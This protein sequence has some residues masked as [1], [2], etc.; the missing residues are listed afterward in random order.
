MEAYEISRNIELYTKRLTD[1]KNT[2]NLE[3]LEANIKKDEEISFSPT[4]YNDIDKSQQVLKRIKK[5][6]NILNTFK[7]I[8]TY[9][10]DLQCLYDLQKN[11]EISEADNNNDVTKVIANVNNLLT[12]FEKQM[13]LNGEYDDCDALMELHPGAGGTE[14]QDWAAMLLRMYRRYAEAHNFDFEIVD[15]ID[16][17]EAGLKSVT[18]VVKGDNAYGYLKSEHGVH[19]MVRISPFDAGNR[20]HT[21]FAG[22]I[23]TPVI[24]ENINIEIKQEDIRVDTYRSTGSGGQ[25]VNK[26]D[27]AVR[28]THL[29]TGI[30]V[31][32]QSQRS[33]LQNREKAM[34][35]LKSKLYQLE[36]EENDRK[37]KNINGDNSVNGFGGQIRSYVF[38]PYSLVKDLRTNYETANTDG[39]LD[40][41]LDGLI[42]SYMHYNQK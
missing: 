2:I 1:L 29:K 12:N 31:T 17:E 25:Y 24:T 11:E 38:H 10:D 27:S 42:E 33:Q 13:L 21:T 28:I 39:V 4:F 6:K 35:L 19:R 34:Q 7:N 32:C 8:E 23:V 41:D 14:A 36:K 20:R 37:L 9:L 40:G 16:G 30:V 3:E 5:N 18:F 22:C 15:Y 26:T